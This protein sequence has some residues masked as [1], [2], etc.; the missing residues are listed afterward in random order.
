MRTVFDYF[1]VGLVFLLFI[2]SDFSEKLLVLR[3]LSVAGGGVSLRYD[4][5]LEDLTLCTLRR[6]VPCDSSPLGTAGVNLCF[7]TGCRTKTVGLRVGVEGTDG[8]PSSFLVLVVEAIV[9]R[10]KL[11]RSEVFLELSV[12]ELLFS[13]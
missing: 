4:L 8:G 13:E 11:G 3:A 9:L 7:I 6:L 1:Q 12:C 10:A 5:L 2:V